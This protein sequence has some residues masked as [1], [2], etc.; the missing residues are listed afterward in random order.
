MGKGGERTQL[1]KNKKITIE[2][3]AKHRTPED[4]NNF[5]FYYYYSFIS[6]LTKRCPYS[7]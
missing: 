5:E 6:S 4:G 2:E 3:L 1:S 7:F